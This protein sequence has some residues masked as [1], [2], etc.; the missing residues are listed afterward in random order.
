MFIVVK[1][2]CA[3]PNSRLNKFLS[4]TYKEWDKSNPELF[5]E[6]HRKIFGWWCYPNSYH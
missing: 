4:N 1:S 5:S 2:K 3:N 6:L